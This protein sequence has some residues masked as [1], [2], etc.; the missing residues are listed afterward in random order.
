MNPKQIALIVTGILIVLGAVSYSVWR[1][2]ERQWTSFTSEQPKLSFQH[3]RVFKVEPLPEE[4][5]RRLDFLFRASEGELTNPLNVNLRAETGLR[6]PTSLTKQEMIPML[7]G[8][9]E[10]AY[11]QRFPDFKKESERTFEQAGK[12]AAELLFIYT[13]PAGESIKQRLFIIAYDGD[14]ALYLAAQSKEADFDELNHKYFNRM[15]ASLKFE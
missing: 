5:N 10:A 1:Y 14:T 2:Q 6:L 15:F 4:K 8:N 3:P 12:K 9:I 13:G 7:L 11:P